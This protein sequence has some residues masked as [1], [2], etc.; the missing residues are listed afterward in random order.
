M[1][2]HNLLMWRA[3]LWLARQGHRRLDLGPIDTANAPGLA[4]FKLGIGAHARRLGGTWGWWPP[5]GSLLG[6]LAALDR[7]RMGP[8]P[9]QSF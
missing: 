6:P 3:A 5:L 8:G 7:A 1:S 2:A 9:A 4:R